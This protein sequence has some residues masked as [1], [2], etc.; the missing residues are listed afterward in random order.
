MNV[1]TAEAEA[2]SGPRSGGARTGRRLVL[3][4]V[5]L[6]ALAGVTVFAWYAYSQNLHGGHENAPPLL[7]AE[8]GPVKIRPKDPGGMDPPHQDKFIYDRLA[9]DRAGAEPEVLLP[10]PEDPMAPPAVRAETSAASAAEAAATPPRTQLADAGATGDGSTISESERKA[11]VEP[12]S[13]AELKAAEK[14]AAET[15][16]KAAAKPAAETEP[17][18]AMKPAAETE[19][20]AEA[21]PAAPE[22][23][24]PERESAATPM[25]P[26]PAAPAAP[27]APSK[28][29]AAAATIEPAAGAAAEQAPKQNGERTDE[30]P[31]AAPAAPA[32]QERDQAAVAPSER[33]REQARA[34]PSSPYRI[35]VFSMRSSE[36]A[37]SS[38]ALLRSDN[39]D[40]LK[41]LMLYIQRVDLGADRGIYF[42]VQAGPFVDQ[43]AAEALCAKL[44]ERSVSCL[45]VKS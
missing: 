33:P 30:Q 24:A 19:P 21:G 44:R 26:E 38:W 3:S 2:A 34:A 18:A 29:A 25:P 20:K 27:A 42:R 14:P 6:G 41:D 1:T 45:V 39:K 9:P 22:A 13:G 4:S 15:E 31:A 35:Q 32:R 12:A 7:K 17:K 40:L 8:A 5:T 16:P 23:A 37:A 11:A 36:D 43:A 10:R 28:E